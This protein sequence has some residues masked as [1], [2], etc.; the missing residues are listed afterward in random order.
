M[1]ILVLAEHDNNSLKAATLNTIAAASEIGGDIVVLVAG[2]DCGGAAE[3]AASV[4]GVA[5]VLTADNAAYA[6][7]LAEN[8]SLLVAELGTAYTHILGS[9]TTS[10]KNIMPRVAALLDV[11]MIS[12]IS[13]VESADTFKRPI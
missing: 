3:Q 12:E 9:A 13:S 1:S 7:Q 2:Q 4:A 6:N 5:K 8:V 11:A 10:G